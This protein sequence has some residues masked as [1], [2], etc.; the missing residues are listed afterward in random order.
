MWTATTISR[1]PRKGGPSRRDPLPHASATEASRPG[2]TLRLLSYNIQT[3]IATT[4]PHHYLTQTWKQVLPH[5]RFVSNLDRI[6][7]VVAPYDI[8]ALQEVDAGSLRTGFL[9]QTQYLASQAGFPYWYYQVN[10]NFGKLARVS[11]GFLSRLE[12]TEI[13]KSRLPGTL[14]GR[15]AMVM[16]FGTGEDSL[17]F[18]GIHL[19]LG[20]YSRRRQIAHLAEL[21]NQYRHVVVMGDMNCEVGSQEMDRLLETTRLRKPN[22][23]MRTFPS[24]RPHWHLDHILVTDTLTVTHEEVLDQSIS[25]HLPVAMEVVVPAHLLERTAFLSTVRDRSIDSQ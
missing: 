4:R 25:D 23:G 6:A 3:G 21:V 15:S 12:P 7:G 2:V 14:P 11:L 20:R 19:A 9:N 16:R 18:V 13:W 22:T 1:K 10:R 17:L 24:W 8:V 5:T